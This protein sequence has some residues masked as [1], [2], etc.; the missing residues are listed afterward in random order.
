V[1]KATFPSVICIGNVH[2][3]IVSRLDLHAYKWP[4][5]KADEWPTIRTHIMQSPVVIYYTLQGPVKLEE[6]FFNNFSIYHIYIS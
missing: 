3:C 5:V 6:H 1:Y 4:N 2:Y